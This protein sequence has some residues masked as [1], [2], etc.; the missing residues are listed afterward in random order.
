MD[1]NGHIKLYRSILDSQVFAHQ[2][3]LKIWIWCLTKA[4]YK[5]RF[6]PL[7][8]GKGLITIKVNPGQFIFGRLKAE[9]ELGIDGSTIYKWMQK[10]SS[11]AFENMITLK[12]NNQYTIITICNWDSYQSYDNQEVTTLEQPRNNQV[13]TKEQPRNTNKKDNK[14]NKVNK[15]KKESKVIFKEKIKYS[16]FV[17][18]EEDEFEKL[19]SEFGQDTYKLIEILNNY[20]GANGKKYKS[21]YLAIRNWVIDRFKN[22]SIPQ[23]NIQQKG[24]SIITAMQMF[25]E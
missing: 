16:E 1:N 8:I 25:Q 7:K 23:K 4:T 19:Y 15:D 10:F 3:A 13:A 11:D 24:T 12:S 18:M 2:T 17:S 14:D 20:K 22:N 9:E 6:I 21:D 5:E